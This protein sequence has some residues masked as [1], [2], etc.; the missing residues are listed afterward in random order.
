M[1]AVEKLE[2]GLC[3]AP[4]CRQVVDNGQAV[5]YVD[6]DGNLQRVCWKHWREVNEA[7][8]AG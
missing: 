7:P 4:R 1:T 3:T 6:A 2:A 8:P 5:Q